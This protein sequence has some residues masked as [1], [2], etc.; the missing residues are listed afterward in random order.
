MQIH[1]MGLDWTGQRL[2]APFD[3]ARFT[4]ELIAK[5]ATN[6]P[7]VRT[8]MHTGT[9]GVA[10]R[11]EATP[12]VVD[13]SDARSVGWTILV[14]ATDPQRDAWL[15]VL[16]PLAE[17][18]GME[19]PASPLQFTAR[20]PVDWTG[21]LEDHYFAR[22]LQGKQVPRYVLIVGGPDQVPFGFQSLLDTVASVGRV[23]FDR[24]EDLEAYVQKLIRLE[25]AKD[26]VVAREAIVFATDGGPSDPTHYSRRFMATPMEEILSGDLGI[27]TTT[28]YAD[29]ATKPGLASALG[30]RRPALVYTA[31]H[32]LGALRETFDIQSRYNGAICCQHDGPLTLD[33]LYSVD[34]VPDDSQPFLE[35]AVFFQFACYGY[36]TPAESEYAHWIETW[37][38]A[39]QNT[40]HDFVAALPRRLLAHPRGPIAYIGHLDTAFLHGFADAEA[41]ET[42]E[43]WHSRLAP[44][45]SAVKQL[46]G[47]RPSGLAMEPMSHRYATLSAA[48]ANTYDRMQRGRM[49]WTPETQAR[50]LDAWITRGDAQNYMVFGDPAARLRMPTP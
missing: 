50:F 42:F 16:R 30:A 33:S 22:E 41:P 25:S 35:G 11:G 34:D 6:G 32:G 29:Q 18:R 2:F 48:I 28:L 49:Q 31:S 27:A 9:R 8:T 4:D 14:N 10:F 45:V 23:S 24:T 43:R 47:V 20:D 13:V 44:Y 40:D 26:P 15:E 17:R 1:A 39:K 38:Q 12:D 37:G 5:L 3:A 19:D 21:W 7:Q 36:G 46:I